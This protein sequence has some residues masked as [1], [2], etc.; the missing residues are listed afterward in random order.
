MKKQGKRGIRRGGEKTEGGAQRGQ[1]KIRWVRRREGWNLITRQREELR[2]DKTRKGGLEEEEGRS[3]SHDRGRG[4]K[5]TKQGYGG[6]KEEENRLFQ[7]I[8]N[9]LRKNIR[10][11]SDNKVKYFRNIRVKFLTV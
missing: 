4:S 8:I 5:G 7:F 6:S 1:N 10:E 9:L 3:L 11:C 2:G